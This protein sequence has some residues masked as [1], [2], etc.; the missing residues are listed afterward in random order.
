MARR[1]VAVPEVFTGEGSQ[2]WSDWQ[3]HID[4]VDGWSAADKKKWVRARLTGRAVMILQI[5]RCYKYFGWD[6]H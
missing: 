3:D 2:R 6:K 4:S 1:P 5:I